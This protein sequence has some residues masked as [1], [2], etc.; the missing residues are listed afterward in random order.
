MKYASQRLIRRVKAVAALL[1]AGTV[2]QATGCSADLS[3]QLFN[4]T[5]TI[6]T[7]LI[8]SYVNDQLGVTTG[9]F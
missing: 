5:S 9:F 8:T 6:L 7:Q 3:E 2:F 4:L 1:S